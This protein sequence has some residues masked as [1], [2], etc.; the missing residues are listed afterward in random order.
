MQSGGIV[1]VTVNTTQAACANGDVELGVPLLN[2][3]KCVS[4]SGEGGAIVAYLKMALQLL[5]GGVGGVIVLMLVIAGIQYIVSAG[6]PG[7]IKKAKDRI[8]NAITALILFVMSYAILG[9]LI[10]GG[11]F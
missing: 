2:G 3:Q 8:V 1:R 11:I 10:P 4:N 7:N 9:F 5:T 6:D